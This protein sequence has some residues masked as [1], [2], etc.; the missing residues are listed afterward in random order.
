MRVEIKTGGKPVKDKDI[1]ALYLMQE[2]MKL[3]SSEKMR[4]ANL[5]FIRSKWKV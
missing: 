4:K 3:S 1:K 2:A 5:D